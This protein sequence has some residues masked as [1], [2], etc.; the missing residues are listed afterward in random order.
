MIGHQSKAHLIVIFGNGLAF[1]HA[2][3]NVDFFPNFFTFWVIGMWFENLFVLSTCISFLFLYLYK[4]WCFVYYIH[5]LQEIKTCQCEFEWQAH[6]SLLLLSMG[7]RFFWAG[8]SPPQ[9]VKGGVAQQRI[10]RRPSWKALLYVFTFL[11]RNFP[12]SVFFL[13]WNWPRIHWPRIILPSKISRFSSDF[14]E[15]PT[16]FSFFAVKIVKL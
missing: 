9:S 3:Y 8:I 7:R 16:Y 4:F 6:I 15:F 14:F 5:M 10:L 1:N 2:M 11:E 12:S 13:T